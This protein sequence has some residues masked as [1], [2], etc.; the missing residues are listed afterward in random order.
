MT[1]VQTVGCDNDP[2]GVPT[3]E[4]GTIVAGNSDQYTIEVTVDGGTSGTL[5]NTATVASDVFDTDN[6]NDTASVVTK[7]N[8]GFSFVDVNND[9]IYDAGQ[10]IPLD[11]GE[12][13]DGKF[14]TAIPEGPDYTVAVAGA[15]LSVNGTAISAKDVR[16]TSDGLMIINTNLTATKRNIELE[17]RTDNVQFD[18][19]TIAGNKKIRVTAAGDITSSDDEFI[20]MAN[21]SNVIFEAGNDIVF[22]DTNVTAGRTVSFKAGGEVRI[23]PN[24]SVDVMGNRGRTT[25]DAGDVNVSGATF[26]AGLGV[27]IEANN[28]NVNVSDTTITSLVNSSSKVRLVASGSVIGNAGTDIDANKTVDVKAG[29]EIDLDG[30]QIAANTHNNSKLILDAD[31]LRLNGAVLESQR[32]IILEAVDAIHAANVQLLACGNPKSIIRA[33][34]GGSADFTGATARAGTLIDLLAADLLDLEES[35]LG[36]TGGTKGDILLEGTTIDVTNAVFKAP[37][38]LIRT[39]TEIGVPAD[40]TPGTLPCI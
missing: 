28:G 14:D 32:R 31:V 5:T 19:S 8:P 20:G 15:G 34:A 40:D 17:S 25:I 16:F 24:S 29:Q 23:N 30:V 35:S 36:I 2:N 6:S 21:S 7:V 22:V 9:G 1:F 11:D 33:T 13:D 38:D 27:E 3:C 37:D 26:T 18:D 4:P 12:L 10:D 39:G